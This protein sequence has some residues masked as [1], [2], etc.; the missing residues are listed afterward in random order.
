MQQI[1]TPFS[2]VHFHTGNRINLTA[3]T[4]VTHN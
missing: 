2:G 4:L 1:L 3:A